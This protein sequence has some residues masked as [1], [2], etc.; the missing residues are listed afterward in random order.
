MCHEHSVLLEYFDKLTVIP[1]QNRSDL[2]LNN[3]S[4]KWPNASLGPLNKEVHC[5]MQD[6]NYSYNV[7]SCHQ[8]PFTYGR[9]TI[10]D[11]NRHTD[12]ESGFLHRFNERNIY[13]HPKQKEFKDTY[14][15]T[16]M[17]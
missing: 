15:D 14:R 4:T 11:R 3:Q 7:N 2:H 6:R 12:C 9:Q 13:V 1:S 17:T 16:N 5:P 10:T 8:V